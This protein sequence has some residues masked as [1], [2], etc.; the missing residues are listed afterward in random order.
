VTH[1]LLCL[2]ALFALGPLVIFV[3][4]ALKSQ[5]EL[6]ASPLSI[7]SSPSG[8]TPDRLQQAN[9]GAGLANSAI[10]VGGT[11]PASA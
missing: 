8:A 4:S 5:S 2:L 7:P 10:V 9:M 3:F 1:V 11:S 6:A